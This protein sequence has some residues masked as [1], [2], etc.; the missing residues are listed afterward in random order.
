MTLPGAVLVP[1]SHPNQIF[2]D[3]GAPN[4]DLCTPKTRFSSVFGHRKL[5]FLVIRTFVLANIQRSTISNQQ[6]TINNKQ[7]TINNQ[8]SIIN[9]QQST[10]NNQEQASNNQQSS[11]KNQQSKIDKIFSRFSSILVHFW[12]PK[13]IQKSSKTGDHH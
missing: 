3:F 6:S 13:S 1:K 10:F 7:T 4:V 12:S 11:I 5:I 8:R 2:F 9:N